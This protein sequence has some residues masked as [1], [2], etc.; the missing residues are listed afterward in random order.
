MKYSLIETLKLKILSLILKTYH[1]FVATNPP[2]YI[3]DV[4]ID[5]KV[6]LIQLKLSEGT[7]FGV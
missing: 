2:F 1:T 3:K 7:N 5:L 6:A 4:H